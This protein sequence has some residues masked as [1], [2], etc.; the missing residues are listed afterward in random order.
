[1]SL[2]VVCQITVTMFIIII[3][4]II[5]INT[6]FH[7]FGADDPYGSAMCRWPF[8]ALAGVWAQ[9]SNPALANV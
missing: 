1:M 3:I 5:I 4:I 6:S 9:P 2:V 7:A 8:H